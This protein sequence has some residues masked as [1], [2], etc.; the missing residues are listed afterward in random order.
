MKL[1]LVNVSFE[2]LLCSDGGNLP[3]TSSTSTINYSNR[4]MGYQKTCMTGRRTG[5]KETKAYPTICNL[6]TTLTGDYLRQ[7][8]KK[9]LCIML[10]K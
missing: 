6:L 7:N 3:D 5:D 8:A 4:F 9:W 10:L 1:Y 2:F